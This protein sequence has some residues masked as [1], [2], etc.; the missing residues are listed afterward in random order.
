MLKKSEMSPQMLIDRQ[1]ALNATVELMSMQDKYGL[2]FSVSERVNMAITGNE[3]AE[4]G[5]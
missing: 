5:A 2:E 4:K 1:P 3:K